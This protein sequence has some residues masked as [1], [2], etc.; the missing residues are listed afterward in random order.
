MSADH[1]IPNRLPAVT[2]SRAEAI[3]HVAAQL[4]IRTV[5]IHNLSKTVPAIGLLSK[6]MI[7]KN[8]AAAE[9]LGCLAEYSA[10]VAQITG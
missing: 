1:R 4:A 9:T 10:A 8:T 6:E 3:G 2:M 5:E 7:A